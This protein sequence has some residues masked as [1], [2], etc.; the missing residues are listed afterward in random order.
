MF[1]AK[2]TN[3]HGCSS[4]R[5]V[6]LNQSSLT[7]AV[8]EYVDTVHD[9]ENLTFSAAYCTVYSHM[10]PATCINLC[11]QLADSMRKLRR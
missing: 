5:T 10:A 4:M 7:A 3:T 1:P 9:T 11:G 8:D 6:L 2:V